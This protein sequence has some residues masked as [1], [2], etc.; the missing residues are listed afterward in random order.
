MAAKKSRAKKSA[1]KKSSGQHDTIG[2]ALSV[3]AAHA[4]HAAAQLVSD[5]ASAAIFGSDHPDLK[6]AR[7]AAGKSAKKSSAKKKSARKRT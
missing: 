1:A 4:L 5:F 6:D 2:I 3:E 7:A